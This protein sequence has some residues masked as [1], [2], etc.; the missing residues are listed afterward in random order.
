[1]TARPRSCRRSSAQ[2]SSVSGAIAASLQ[3]LDMAAIGG[4]YAAIAPETLDHFADERRQLR[5]RA[6]MAPCI[7]EKRAEIR[8]LRAQLLLEISELLPHGPPVGVRTTAQEL[9]LDV[10][11]HQLLDDA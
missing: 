1:M 4:G 6:V 11:V 8:D 2:W 10:R 3:F 9:N 7:V 5:G